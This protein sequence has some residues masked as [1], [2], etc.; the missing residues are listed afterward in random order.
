LGASEIVNL[1]ISQAPASSPTMEKSGLS[2]PKHALNIE[3][4]SRLFSL[5][6]R[7]G[8][9][10]YCNVLYTKLCSTILF[11]SFLEFINNIRYSKGGI[12]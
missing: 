11:K 9:P 3:S 8:V 5:K 7:S 12:F 2:Y 10:I 4:L 1:F 6:K